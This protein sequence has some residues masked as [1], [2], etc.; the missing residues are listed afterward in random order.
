MDLEGKIYLVKLE[1]DVLT[2]EFQSTLGIN[3]SQRL[4]LHLEMRTSWTDRHI[5]KYY[6][7]WRF[8]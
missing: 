4:I 5:T 7:L 2:I 3:K 6:S 8:K 1:T